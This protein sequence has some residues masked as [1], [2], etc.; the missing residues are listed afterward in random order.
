MLSIELSE[1]VQEESGGPECKENCGKL[2]HWFMRFQSETRIL[3]GPRLEAI[4]V[5]FLQRT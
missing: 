2:A 4:H 5:I 3:S 1:S